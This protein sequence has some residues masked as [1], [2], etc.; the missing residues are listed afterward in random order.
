MSYH[1]T[2][3]IYDLSQGFSNIYSEI[4]IGKRISGIWHTGIIIHD[5]EYFYSSQ[6]IIEAI[7]GKTIAGTPIRIKRL[8]TTNI[9]L[10]IF[11]EYINNLSNYRFKGNKYDLMKHNCN[12]FSSECSL[13]LTGKDI[14]EYIN[15]LPEEVFNS[16]VGLLLNFFSYA[17]NL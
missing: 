3:Y 5:K 15:K 10:S 6:G 7:P 12:T 13:F 16:P 11:S 4:I 2:L 1:V 17:H 9:P 8:G 14:P